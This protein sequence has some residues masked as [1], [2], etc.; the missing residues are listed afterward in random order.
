MSPCKIIILPAADY[1][2]TW[3]NLYAIVIG[4]YKIVEAQA[5]A[6]NDRESVGVAQ[7]LMAQAFGLAADLWGDVPFTQAGNA[8]LYPTP[9]FDKQMDVYNGVLSLLD[10]AIANMNSGVGNGVGTK[11]FY[12]QGNAANWVAV[13]NTLKA[14]YYLHIRDYADALTSAQA[15]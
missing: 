6:V 4:Q 9:A 3:D 8:A 10:S 14:R 7:I 1:N 13:A 5:A 11:D 15:E 2:D 12:F